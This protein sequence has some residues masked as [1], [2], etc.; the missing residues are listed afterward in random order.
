[1]ATGTVCLEVTDYSMSMLAI[2]KIGLVQMS[3][4]KL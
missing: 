4:S 2:G 3:K 1:M